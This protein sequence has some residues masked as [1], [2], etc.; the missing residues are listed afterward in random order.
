MLGSAQYGPGISGPGIRRRLTT[1]TDYDKLII[2]CH[3]MPYHAISNHEQSHLEQGLERLHQGVERLF[4]L[5]D[6]GINCS[7]LAT[8]KANGPS[9]T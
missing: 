4:Q 2:S 1:S 8:S 7:S 6:V 9:K 3:I 5:W